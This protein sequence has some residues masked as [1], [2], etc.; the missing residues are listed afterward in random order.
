MKEER[1][2]TDKTDKRNT[3]WFSKRQAEAEGAIIYKSLRNG[4]PVLASCVSEEKPDFEDVSK[5][6][7]AV[8][9][10]IKISSEFPPPQDTKSLKTNWGKYGSDMDSAVDVAAFLAHYNNIVNVT[11]T[12]Q[13]AAAATQPAADHGVI[14]MNNAVYER[15]AD[16]NP[17]GE[18]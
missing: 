11:A 9:G 13:P 16:Y 18:H 8:G 1:D 3:A 6:L 14:N 4:Y 7:G 10:I 5:S 12:Q 17:A 2:I 15:I